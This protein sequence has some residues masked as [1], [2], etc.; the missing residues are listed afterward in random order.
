MK[1]YLAGKIGSMDWRHSVVH[2]LYNALEPIE[3]NG[4][5]LVLPDRWPTLKNSIFGQHDY[6]GP[7]F[8][9]NLGIHCSIHGPD[10]H[11]NGFA[12]DDMGFVQSG[13]VT[14]EKFDEINSNHNATENT[15]A[16]E[17]VAMLCLQAIIK[18][19]VVFVWMD[20]NTAFGTLFELGFALAHRKKIWW[21]TP[22]PAYSEWAD[23]DMWFAKNFASERV[24]SK[25]AKSALQ[26]L[27]PKRNFTTNGY[28]YILKS[29]EHF[30]IGKSINVD[31]RVTQISPKTPL[32]VTLIHSI[33]SNNM[34]AAETMLHHR[35]ASY[36]TNGEWFR[37]PEYELNML[38][39][40]PF[41][42]M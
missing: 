25:S 12:D 3:E 31:Q 14:K 40:I 6:T 16:K 2:N 39:D 4:N 29:G 10:M 37:L 35:C 15:G 27:L 18:S 20:S 21:A 26:S 13:Y 38:L 11:G 17:L 9:N 34:S 5:L 22:N 42:E 24:V 36:R 23:K 33:P 28:V 32:P 1:I 8:T 19:D 7:F 30:K 41:L